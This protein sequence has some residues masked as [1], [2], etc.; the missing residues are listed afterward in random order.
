MFR[1]SGA[2]SSRRLHV[3]RNIGALGPGGFRDVAVVAVAARRID[4]VIWHPEFGLRSGPTPGY[5][6]KAV[7]LFR[8]GAAVVVVIYIKYKVRLQKKFSREYN[9]RTIYLE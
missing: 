1:L 4:G 9:Q 5:K 8:Y 7:Q 6:M 2:S 3:V